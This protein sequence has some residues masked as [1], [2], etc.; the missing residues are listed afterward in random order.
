MVE[1]LEL[2]RINLNAFHNSVQEFKI[3]EDAIFVVESE[4]SSTVFHL[5]YKV[6]LHVF[7]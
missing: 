2:V 7:D 3:N 5:E 4:V 6:I 1:Q